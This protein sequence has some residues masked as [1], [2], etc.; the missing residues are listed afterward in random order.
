MGSLVMG[1]IAAILLLS[2]VTLTGGCGYRPLNS[3]ITR[4]NGAL[5][6]IYIP[7][8]V[9]R[10]FRPNLEISLANSLTEQFAR[11]R[12]EWRIAGESADYILSGTI[13]G[14]DRT[15]VAYTRQDTVAEYRATITTEI[16]LKKNG[17]VNALFKRRLSQF[18]HFPASNDI[19]VQQSGED[20]AIQQVCTRMAETIFVSLGDDF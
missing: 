18:Q 20:A 7:V 9:N 5:K 16:T 6:S 13:V 17:A 2:L 10:S 19:G 1:R 4:D 3:T 15:A 12:G 11:R 8:F 14:Y